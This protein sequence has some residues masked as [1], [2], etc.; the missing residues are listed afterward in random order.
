MAFHITKSG[1]TEPCG[2]TVK[3]CPLGAANHFENLDSAA[4]HAMTEANSALAETPILRKDGTTYEMDEHEAYMFVREYGEGAQDFYFKL[5]MTK[6]G[7]DPE[8]AVALA[9][10][11]VK[12][13]KLMAAKEAATPNLSSGFFG[14]NKG[15]ADS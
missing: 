5:F 15:R 8:D 11:K 14:F 10:L 12:S 2:A 7:L 4:R 6:R 9:I 1:K 13:A 3:A